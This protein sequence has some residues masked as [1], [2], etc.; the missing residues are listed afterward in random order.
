MILTKK[1][2]SDFINTAIIQDSKKILID[3]SPIKNNNGIFLDE[4]N[5]GNIVYEK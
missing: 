3:I 1:E 5:K 2:K 4:I